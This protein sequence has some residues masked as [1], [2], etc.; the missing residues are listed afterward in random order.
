MSI[1]EKL[2]T[3][4][5]NEAK[6]YRAGQKSEYD[7]FWDAIAQKG[8]R[9][10]YQYAFCRWSNMDFKPKYEFNFT[11]AFW[12][13]AYS[14]FVE[15]DIDFDLSEATSVNNMFYGCQKLKTIKKIKLKADGSQSITQLLYDCPAL[16]NVVFEGCIGSNMNC[17][18]S[19]LLSHDSLV[20]VL[21]AVSEEKQ[22]TLTL[23][24]NAV[25][26]AFETVAGAM[27]GS[28]S[29]EWAELIAAK[30]DCTV[31]LI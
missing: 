26:K 22:I 24:Q 18:K 7:R 6:V 15:L 2:N 29:G 5:N 28:K 10:N 11:N 23:S 30:G 9:T 13:F 21:N 8:L 31:S 3:I 16:V 27:D 12:A 1:A 19:T 20:S 14:G 25:D 17:A 4:I